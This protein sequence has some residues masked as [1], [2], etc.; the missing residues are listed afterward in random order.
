[1]GFVFPFVGL[2]LFFIP[3]CMNIE[4]EKGF[5]PNAPGFFDQEEHQVHRDLD[6]A[7]KRVIEEEA[8]AEVANE[9]AIQ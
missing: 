6:A 4:K 7:R 9:K 1:M 5:D 3:M 8:V 2:L